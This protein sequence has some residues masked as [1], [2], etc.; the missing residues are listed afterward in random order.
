[1]VGYSFHFISFFLK[2]KKINIAESAPLTYI[3]MGFFFFTSLS[4]YLS[5]VCRLYAKKRRLSLL[6]NH[7]ASVFRTEIQREH[8]S[9]SSN[10]VSDLECWIS[11]R[12][13]WIMNYTHAVFPHTRV[14]VNDAVSVYVK[15]PLDRWDILC[16]FA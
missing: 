11:K 5:F 8:N 15:R 13:L 9:K 10:S 1:L 4:N 2:K 3:V 7:F 12:K 16:C 14:K 6:A